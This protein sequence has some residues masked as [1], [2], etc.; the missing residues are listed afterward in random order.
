MNATRPVNL[1]FFYYTELKYVRMSDFPDRIIAIW[2]LRTSTNSEGTLRIDT[3]TY[4]NHVEIYARGKL[5]TDSNKVDDI[6]RK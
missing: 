3:S 5:M 4:W 1:P 6:V 2:R